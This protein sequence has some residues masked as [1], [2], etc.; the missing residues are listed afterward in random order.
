M[1]T[2]GQGV[3]KGD[4][5]YILELDSGEQLEWIIYYSQQWQ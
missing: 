3:L 2:N 1:T 5:E 4:N